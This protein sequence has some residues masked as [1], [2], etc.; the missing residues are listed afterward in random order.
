MVRLVGS[1]LV[2]QRV[3]KVARSRECLIRKGIAPENGWLDGS[4]PFGAFRPYFQV[5]C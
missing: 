1:K 3:A 5:L 2:P 4:D